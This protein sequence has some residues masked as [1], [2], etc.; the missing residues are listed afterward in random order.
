MNTYFDIET[1]PDLDRVKGTEWFPD[2]AVSSYEASIAECSLLAISG[3]TVAGIE[4][5]VENTNPN[6]R[7]LD[8]ALVVEQQ[9]KNRAGVIK[10]LEKRRDASLAAV[11][12]CSLSP[13]LC[14]ICAYGYALGD[15]D[16]KVMCDSEFY[17]CEVDAL[18][19]FWSAVVDNTPVGFNCLS[20]D[21]PVIMVRSIINGIRPSRKLDI[22]RYSRDVIDLFVRRT[23]GYP[24]SG[25]N[26][27]KDV[28][29][30]YGLSVPAE[31]SSGGDVWKWWSSGDY[32]QIA[33]YQASDVEITRSLYRLY[34]GYFC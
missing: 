4:K 13:E 24:G 21:L 29:K 31:G 17:A 18:K 2:V 28:A 12:V 26:K 5:I 30:L 8:E 11:K 3:Q 1:V 23:G 25:P 6:P 9:G 7:W 10:A 32:D 19:A 16:V 15:G 27:M 33:R 14:R 34:Q 20:F 22:G